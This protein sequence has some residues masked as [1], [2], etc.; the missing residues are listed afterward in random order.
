MNFYDHFFHTSSNV[1][2]SDVEV[3]DETSFVEINFKWNGIECVLKTQSVDAEFLQ[4]ELDNFEIRFVH[5]NSVN[6]DDQELISMKEFEKLPVEQQIVSCDETFRIIQLC[7]DTFVFQVMNQAIIESLETY[8]TLCLIHFVTKMYDIQTKWCFFNPMI[9]NTE[10]SFVQKKTKSICSNCLLPSETKFQKCSKCIQNKV[11]Y[12]S[13][14][15]Q[16]QHWNEH[17]SVCENK[18]KSP[19]MQKNYTCSFCYCSSFGQKFQLCGGCINKSK[20]SENQ[21]DFQGTYYCSQNCQK[22]HWK[23]HKK[24]CNKNF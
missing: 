6:S 22:Q 1:T 4:K 3:K 14:E 15:C 20:P 9:E 23:E 16:K 11:Y 19:K 12:C 18:S 5:P 21:M 2:Q 13:K 17:K 24:V 8:S 10:F 7:I